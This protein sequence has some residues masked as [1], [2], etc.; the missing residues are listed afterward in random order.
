M[1][2]PAVL[3]RL[4]RETGEDLAVLGVR[5]SDDRWITLHAEAIASLARAEPRRGRLAERLLRLAR[6]AARKVR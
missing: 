3:G 4:A 6:R 1:I 2:D 5:A